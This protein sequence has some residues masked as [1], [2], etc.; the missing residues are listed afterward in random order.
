MKKALIILTV[1]IVLGVASYF[2]YTKWI[3]KPVASTTTPAPTSTQPTNGMSAAQATMSVDQEILSM[4][5]GF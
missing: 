4:F 1:L 2:I 3:K 5:A